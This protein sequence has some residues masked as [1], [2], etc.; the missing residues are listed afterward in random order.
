M[1]TTAPASVD[2]IRL[3]IDGDEIALDPSPGIELRLAVYPVESDGYADLLAAAS[4]AKLRVGVDLI[5]AD[6]AAV[7]RCESEARR[8]AALL[9]A[10]GG[11]LEPL[12][13]FALEAALGGKGLPYDRVSVPR[14]TLTPGGPPFLD[15]EQQA[16]GVRVFTATPHAADDGSKYT[17]W[18]VDQ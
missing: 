8:V 13:E 11:P 2:W 9:G 3:T 1:T 18:R 15:E 16:P 10:N 17:M 12:R 6:A 4:P 14:L 5:P 7:F